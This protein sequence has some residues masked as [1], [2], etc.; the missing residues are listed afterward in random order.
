VQGHCS[1]GATLACLGKGAVDRKLH[2]CAGVFLCSAVG[3]YSMALSALV[4]WRAPAVAPIQ[5]CNLDKCV[6]AVQGSLMHQISVHGGCPPA[7]EV[8]LHWC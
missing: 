6:L 8:S 7:V 5:Q 2:K 1:S 4:S 3:L